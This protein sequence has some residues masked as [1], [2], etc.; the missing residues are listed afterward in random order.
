M[1][2]ADDAPEPRARPH[3][4]WWRRPFALAYAAIALGVVVRAAH[5]LAAD[6][7][8]ND[9]GLFFLMTR[10]VQTSNFHLPAFT[11]YNGGE[12]PF[13]YSPLGFYLAAA[14]NSATGIPLLELFRF[15]PLI[16]TSLIVV[17]FYHLAKAMLGEPTTVG[18]A[19]LAFAL[20]PRSF[21][22]MIMGG[23]LT[24]SI[25]LLAAVVGIHQAYLL[26]TR[27]E[28]RYAA[29]A[30]AAC[31]V[32]V[33]SHLGT[34]PFLAMSIAL[35]FAF[36]GRHRFGVLSSVVV[37]GATVLLTAPWWAAVIAAHG[38]E[39]F[40]AAQNT[41]GSAF[42][43]L[44]TAY[45]V[46]AR[47]ARFNLLTTGEP[48]FP[49]FGFFALLGAFAALRTGWFVL[50]VWWVL[51]VF[52]DVRAGETY[53]TIPGGM[54][55]GLG[56]VVV[57]I[58]LIRSLYAD[59]P[60]SPVVAS[61]AAPALRRRPL[62]PPRVILPLLLGFFLVYGVVSA[63]SRSPDYGGAAL[64]PYLTA[65][66]P[67]ERTLMREIAGRT[68]PTSRFVVVTGQPWFADKVSEWFPVLANRVSVNTVQGS[69]WLPGGFFK[70][71]DENIAIQGTCGNAPVGCLEEWAATTGRDYT[72]VYV[73]KSRLAPCCGR[74]MTSLR[75]SP[76]YAV[77]HDGPAA[78]VAARRVGLATR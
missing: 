65:L 61:I 58:P 22:W 12:I 5:V 17:A 3:A 27:R 6:F 40:I 44:G 42:K 11:T 51:V 66:R 15:L 64:G 70:R 37:A 48:L 33:L 67:E 24:R 16:A 30:A 34:A 1:R 59:P 50:V 60:D 18:A 29:T 49:I 62:L 8:L 38:I 10:E 26:Y 32:T 23:G 53:A 28:W 68:A 72:H 69:E 57:F 76:G 56:I 39:P 9:G 43:D 46:L 41:A 77:I 7:P 75:T 55:A 2:R 35:L 4:R 74:L 21:G 36:Y 45:E 13:A 19:V 78:L 14:I 54:L 20:V 25:G 52:S 31:A 71:V 73:A 47:L 63:L